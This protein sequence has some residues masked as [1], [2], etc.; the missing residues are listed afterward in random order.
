MDSHCIAQCSL[1]KLILCVTDFTELNILRVLEN[2]IRSKAIP[3]EV[4]RGSEVYR[5][6]RLPDFKIVVT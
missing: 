2:R 3:V 1:H 4:W 5:S 6:L